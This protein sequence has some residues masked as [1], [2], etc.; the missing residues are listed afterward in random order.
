MEKIKSQI[1]V[2][3]PSIIGGGYGEFWRSRKRYVVCKGSRAS[4]KSTTAA[5]KIIYNMMKYPLAN[6][7]VIRKT[8]AT[9]KDSCYSQL[10]WAINQL[11]VSHLWHATINPLQLTYIPTGQ[12]IL[13]RGT[14]DSDKIKSITVEHG[15][16]NFAWVE[17]AFEV[18]FEEFDKI[19]KS[20]R[21]QMPEGYFTQWLITFNP[22]SSS[23]W[24]KSY[25]FDVPRDNVLAMTT[26]YHC[27]EFLSDEYIELL[28]YTRLT[29][30]EKYKVD[31]LGEWGI[32]GGRYFGEWRES[33]HVVK[34][35]EIPRNWIKFRSMDFGISKPYAVLWFAVDYD[36][37]LY[38]YRELYGWGGRANVGTGE[39]AKQIG[40]R[41]AK[42]ETRDENISYG[43]LDSACANRTGVSGPT[44]KEEI[45]N[46]LLEN[47]LVSF[48]D[49]SKGRLEG[50]N[51]FKQ[52]LI[53]NKLA[54]GTYKP[55][56]YFFS[57]CIHSIR[58]I[59]MIGHDKHNAE[60][61][62]TDAEDH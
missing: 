57:N 6:C 54:D 17:E 30:P 41:I 46:I 59:P 1:D 40:E 16:I 19:D 24:L 31:G 45:N 28:E 13:F 12:K 58:T 20:L 23:S 43:V 26:T 50:A 34:P 62:D 61:P 52:R 5:L 60:L 27:N 8:A 51:Q 3:L 25:F 18:E 2:D 48:G 38:C 15:F 36:N 47:R 29:D 33:L 4:K 56:I 14:E 53:G 9:L 55:A 42:V 37:N 35:F 7:L 11:K 10:R 22:T 44:I 39:T 21:A 32:E 49:S